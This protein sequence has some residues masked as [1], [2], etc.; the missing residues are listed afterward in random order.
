MTFQYS[1][2]VIFSAVCLFMLSLTAFSLAPKDC[3]AFEITIDVAP[4]VLSLQ[5]NGQVVTVHTDIPYDDVE[6]TSVHIN[7]VL[8]DSWESDVRG[9]FVA[10]FVMNAIKNLPLVIGDYNTFTLVGKT[11]SDGEF[12]GSQDILVVE[13][14][15]K[16]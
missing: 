8:I 13:N 9:Y 16:N 5:N 12:S 2:K 4:N 1:Q 10:R 14:D 15:P 3:H 6:L 7:G 11:F